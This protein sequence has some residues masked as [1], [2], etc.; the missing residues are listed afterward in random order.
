VRV[1][2]QGM[3]D[4]QVRRLP[5]VNCDKRLVGVVSLGDISTGQSP[6][7]SGSARRG[8]SQKH[9]EQERAYGG[10]KPERERRS[11]A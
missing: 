11:E 5:V 1:I 7:V 4:Q 2:A 9:G 6:Q 3:A 8:T 10:N